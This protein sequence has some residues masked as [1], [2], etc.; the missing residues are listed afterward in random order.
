[1][2]DDEFLHYIEQQVNLIASDCFDL[3][4]KQRLS[5][6]QQAIAR[7]LGAPPVILQ[8]GSGCDPEGPA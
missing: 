2:P 7:R 5:E 1:M 6:L 4:A 3:R 8:K